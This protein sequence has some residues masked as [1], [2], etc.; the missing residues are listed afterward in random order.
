MIWALD[1][2]CGRYIE[3][4][5][6]EVSHAEAKKIIIL[7]ALRASEIA[8]HKERVNEV[9]LVNEE[10][11]NVVLIAEEKGKDIYIYTVEYF[12]T[13]NNNWWKK[14]ERDEK[15]IKES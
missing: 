1:H 5:N 6:S 12:E 7:L 10:Q 15:T 4:F 2:A 9:A 14:G 8:R 11:P 3:R 13:Q